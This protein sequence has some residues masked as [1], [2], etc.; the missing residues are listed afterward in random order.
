MRQML[1]VFCII[2][3][4]CGCGVQE[5]E[6]HEVQ[7]P[8]VG[9]AIALPGCMSQGILRRTCTK[10]GAYEDKT[11]EP[12]GH[13]WHREAT[14]EA[15]C[16]WPGMVTDTCTRCGE[17]HEILTGPGA[18][19]WEDRMFLSM[20]GEEAPGEICSLCG[21]W[22]YKEGGEDKGEAQEVHPVVHISDGIDCRG[23]RGTC[24]EP[25]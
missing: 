16:L 14:R 12:L 4:L 5:D 9:G 22:H 2:F 3:L 6:T 8:Y 17:S 25:L 15:T 7:L 18:H 1:T 24:G 21:Q 13:D 11:Y 19:D 20:D 10:C 23:Y